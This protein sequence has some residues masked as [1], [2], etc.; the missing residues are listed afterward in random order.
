L[1]KIE[2]GLSRSGHEVL[3]KDGRWLASSIDPLK[4]ARQW[5]EQFEKLKPGSIF[6]CDDS[7]IILGIGS[8]Y[9]VVEL[10]EQLAKR[11]KPRKLSLR[12]TSVKRVIVLECDAEVCEQTIRLQ[13]KLKAL[14]D[15]GQIVIEPNWLKLVEHPTLRD[16]LGG[17]YQ[18]LKHGASLALE[19]QFFSNVES[20]LLGREKLAFLV[21]LKSRPD[22][23]ATFDADKI[24]NIEDGGVSIKTLQSLFAAKNETHRERRVWKVLEELVL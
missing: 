5:V 14:V 18:I 4:E 6:E 15:R 9:H 16:V 24:S 13:P 22:I 1:T 12:G 23:L 11:E 20:L 17:T 19:Q 10:I 3:K 21:L 7:L 8:G 2:T